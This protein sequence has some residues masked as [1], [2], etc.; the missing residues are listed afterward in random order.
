MEEA[1]VHATLVANL[2]TET[3]SA[4][5]RAVAEAAAA[6]AK[7]LASE[8][9]LITTAI[10]LLRQEVSSIKDQLGANSEKMDKVTTKLNEVAE[11]RPSWAVTL[12]LGLL[13]SLV[14]G[15]AVFVAA[16]L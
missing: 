11:G 6:A 10:A 7:V 1:A 2:V 15:M 4:T 12:I 13:S 14:V 8:N 9:G 5:A 3:A 16:R